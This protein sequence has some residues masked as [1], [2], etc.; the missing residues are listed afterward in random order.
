M[1]VENSSQKNLCIVQ[2]R[3]RSSRLPRKIF[4][5][6]GGLSMLE[7]EITRIRQAK[8]IGLTVVATTTDP[9]DDEVEKLC[10]RLGVECF[11]GSED[12]VLDRY[13]QCAG[14]YPSFQTVV[15]ICGDNPLIDP[16]IIDEVIGV[17]ERSSADYA[18]NVLEEP[19][20]EGMAVEVLSKEAL[21][22]SGQQAKLGSERE[23]VTWHVRTS[24]TFKKIHINTPEDF[25]GYRLTLDR[26]EDFEVIK[27]LIENSKMTDGWNHYK[28]LLDDNPAIRRKNENMPRN[29]G[30]EKSLKQDKGRANST[31][32]GKRALIIQQRKWGPR[33]GHFLARKLQGEGCRLA[34]FTWKKATH[35]FVLEQKDVSYDLI[36]NHEDIANDPVTYLGKDRY[37]FSEMCDELGVDSLW[38]LISAS[39]ILAKSYKDKYYYSFRQNLSDEDIGLYVMALF[40]SIKRIFKEF[41][42]DFLIA[43]NYADLFHIMLNLYGKRH[44]VPSIV[45]VSPRAGRN[46]YVFTES[47]KEDEGTFFNRVDELNSGKTDS[48]NRQLAQTYIKEFRENF[49]NPVF[50]KDVLSKKNS[51]WRKLRSEIA[52][53]YHAI[54]WKREQGHNYL[55]AIGPTIDYRSPRIILRDHFSRKRYKRFME[56]F[57]YYPFEKL[58]KYVY[59]PLQVQP[60]ATVDVTAPYFSNQIEVARLIA[61]SLPDDYVLAVRE[62]PSM[63]GMRPPSYI[64]KLDRTPNVK[65]IDYRLPAHEVLIKSDLVVSPNG[66]A[67][68][69]AAF[70]NKPAIQLG[71]LGTTLKLPNVYKHT[72]MTTIGEKMKELLALDLKTPEYE[73]K[74]ENFLA[75]AYDTGI[76]FS[77]WEAWEKG[78]TDNMEVLWASYKKEILRLLS[79]QTLA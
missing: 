39:R 41:R 58:G 46:L 56:K 38:P 14:Q 9:E 19:V 73:R 15:R 50:M 37:T 69:D 33:I 52:P 12:D 18:S 53:F 4:L 72:D 61:M 79:N 40:K 63:V 20:P 23:H 65:I 24:S 68:A 31:L 71:N 7:H 16:K 13:V 67:L 17:F 51:W 5:E 36:I 75:A 6:V 62:H 3:T 76:R 47:Y 44:G 25:T 29:E 55:E 11:R 1:I 54:M 27:F 64:E 2:A 21:V 26:P 35:R 66:T 42:P 78:Q 60:E 10:K 59:F 8:R 74:L 45:V 22:K 57:N 43:V 28:K 70:Y 34:A 30:L 48:E 32:A 49:V 77:Y